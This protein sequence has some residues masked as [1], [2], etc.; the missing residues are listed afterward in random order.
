MTDSS[1][2][3]VRV[4][5]DC[6]CPGD[7]CDRK[8]RPFPDDWS[9]RCRLLPYLQPHPE[10]RAS[11]W[12]CY[13]C[14]ELFLVE[15][16]ARNHFGATQD[17]EPACKIK[18]AGEFAL[19][20]ALRNAEER[21]ESRQSDDT[22][23]IRAMH[24]M[25][26]DHAQAL[27]LEEE[28]GFARGVADVKAHPESVGLMPIP[29]IEPPASLPPVRA[30]KATDAWAGAVE[31]DDDGAPFECV[32]RFKSSEEA[33]AALRFL[34]RHTPPPL[35]VPID[36]LHACALSNERL[37]KAFRQVRADLALQS[38]VWSN[39]AAYGLTPEDIGV[40]RIEDDV[41]IP[42][43]CSGTQE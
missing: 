21:L 16:D 42:T 12:R 19:L 5:K 38:G 30:L 15:I 20:T 36:D 27:R 40:K 26:S 3:N 34:L 43:K 37:A 4:K 17:A 11:G 10:S 32:M 1:S 24:A 22:D 25:Q 28:K 13:H 9:W 33:S 41:A 2:S 31:I 6:T 14:S 29:A 8:G 35:S 39:A 18:M 7:T 23:A